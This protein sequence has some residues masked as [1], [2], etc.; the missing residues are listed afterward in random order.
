M[1]I[2][3]RQESAAQ[4]TDSASTH[5]YCGPCQPAPQVASHRFLTLACHH[6]TAAG[7]RP[8]ARASA[9]VHSLPA[10]PGDPR[11]ACA[12]RA[13]HPPSSLCRDG[14]RSQGRNACEG[15][16]FQPM[17]LGIYLV[18]GLVNLFWTVGRL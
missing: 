2:Y 16:R 18:L 15:A 7:G 12:P 14:Q 10:L 3:G 9:S 5:L 8:H 6:N 1:Y 17:P 13:P 11:G 4:N